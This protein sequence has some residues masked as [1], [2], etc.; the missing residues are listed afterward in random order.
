MHVVAC[1]RTSSLYLAGHDSSMQDLQLWHV[2]SS[3][4]T[5]D[6]TWLH[7]LG[8]RSLSHWTRVVPDFIPFYGS[9][10]FLFCL[11]S[12]IVVSLGRD[13]PWERRLGGLDTSGDV[14]LVLPGARLGWEPRPPTP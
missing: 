10:L 14:S 7:A 6:L 2:G 12:F 5:K 13:V 11:L 4:P 3:S 9:H 1:F 8:A